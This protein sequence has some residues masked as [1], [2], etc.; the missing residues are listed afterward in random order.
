M[1]TIPVDT[2]Y[3]VCTGIGA[4]GV[5]VIGMILFWESRDVSRIISLLMIIGGIIGR[6]LASG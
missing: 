6:K 1:K 4:V 3:A 5:A 2:A